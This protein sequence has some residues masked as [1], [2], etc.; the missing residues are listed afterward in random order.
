MKLSIT[1]ILLS[2][3][4]YGQEA[5]AGHLI[6]TDE[7]QLNAQQAEIEKQGVWEVSSAV[8]CGADDIDAGV[9]CPPTGAYLPHGWWLSDTKLATV[10][11]VVTEC[12][13]ELSICKEKPTAPFIDGNMF[14]SV[15]LF[16]LGLG[17]GILGGAAVVGFLVLR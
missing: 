15:K 4:A 12:K 13:N 7:D 8:T 5:D 2:R 1:L 9:L 3:L 14:S 16:F 10:A 6:L 11:T 17:I